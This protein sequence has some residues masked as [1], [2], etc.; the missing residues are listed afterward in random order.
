MKMTKLANPITDLVKH[1]VTYLI[2]VGLLFVGL[3]IVVAMYPQVLL[4]FIVSSLLFF[5]LISL[6]FGINIMTLYRRAL[7][8]LNKIKFE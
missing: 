1:L 2:L 7:K 6:L 5:G 3:G 4:V 8:T